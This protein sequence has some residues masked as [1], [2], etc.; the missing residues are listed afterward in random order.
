VLDSRA[1]FVDETGLSVRL[2][3]YTPLSD[4]AAIAPDRYAMLD[5]DGDGQQEM[6]AYYPQGNGT[7]LVFRIYED[8]V[9]GYTFPE[10]DFQN[11]KA[12]GTFLQEKNNYTYTCCRLQF[13]ETGYEL[14]ESAYLDRGKE[15]ARVD[16]KTV[17]AKEG[18]L[19]MLEFWQKTPASWTNG[20]DAVD[21]MS[22]YESFLAGNATASDNWQPQSLSYYLSTDK[23]YN[24]AY[25]DMSGDGRPELCVWSGKGLH[26]F[27]VREKA[28]RL[29]YK[30]ETSS[31]KLMEN[32]MVLDV[33]R[34]Y[35]LSYAYYCYWGLCEQGKNFVQM[36]FSWS[37]S[38]NTYEDSYF[39]IDREV[40]REEYEA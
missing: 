38:K 16:G 23:A 10:S 31:T 12:D 28:L 6:V 7:Y 17:S 15:T 4:G 24:Y 14:A 21:P 13:R 30:G 40:T 33:S 1:A 5:L 8:R 20:P 29:W 39:A 18:A 32:G 27:T 2:N 3:E 34:D 11:L 9:Y 25:F 19:A 35:D 22:L 36:F 37:D 26:I